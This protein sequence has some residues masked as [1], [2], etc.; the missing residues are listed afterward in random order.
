[1]YYWQTRLNYLNPSTVSWNQAYITQMHQH[2]ENG[3]NEVLE[4]SKL[5]FLLCEQVIEQENPKP[6]SQPSTQSNELFFSPQEFPISQ[7]I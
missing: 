3:D 1:M 7:I 4:P 5:I 2:Q 6:V